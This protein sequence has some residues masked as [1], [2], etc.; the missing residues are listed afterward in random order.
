M[1]LIQQ[2]TFLHKKRSNKI[3][4]EKENS[5][6]LITTSQKIK[7]GQWDKNEDELLNQWVKENGPKNWDKC[8]KV[9]KCRNR[10]QCREHWKNKLN[11]EIKKGQWTPED[12]LLILKFYK[13]YKSWK[14]IIPIFENNC[15]TQ[16]NILILI[17][18]Y[19]F[20]KLFNNSVL[21]IFI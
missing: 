21:L 13:K 10:K 19:I 9:I 15:L 4:K 20:L 8:A 1:S 16:H 12:D 2:K 3:L 18:L 6:K 11:E 7:I 14:Q 5:Q 17:I